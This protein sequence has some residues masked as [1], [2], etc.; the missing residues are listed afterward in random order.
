M[1]QHTNGGDNMDLSVTLCV[2]VRAR[3]RTHDM[4]IAVWKY[5]MTSW[6]NFKFYYKLGFLGLV[7]C[8]EGSESNQ[9]L[10]P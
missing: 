8:F 10:Q 7:V 6:D 9:S 2:C 4:V 5:K 1:A 3:T